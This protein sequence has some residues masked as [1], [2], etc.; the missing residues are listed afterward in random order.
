MNEAV[1][2]LFQPTNFPFTTALILM[3][4]VGI[5]AAIGLDVDTDV[6]DGVSLDIDADVGPSDP[7]GLPMPDTG[8]RRVPTMV[9]LSAFLLVYGLIGLATQ[10]WLTETTGEPLSSLVAGFAMLVPAAV[11]MIPT[12]WILRRIL[13]S[14]ETYAVHTRSLV[15]RHGTIDVGTATYDSATP[16]TF[17]DLHGT[18][19][20]LMVTMALKN[21]TATTGERVRLMEVGRKGQPNTVVLIQPINAF[22]IGS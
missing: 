17:R 15:G 2:F 21:E 6:P 16:A 14:D 18:S 22:D 3:I 5:L 13:P 11:A 9:S 1:D 4:F 19:H 12:L 10:Q 8:K 7:N 20:T